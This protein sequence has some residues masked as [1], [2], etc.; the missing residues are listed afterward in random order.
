MPMLEVGLNLPDQQSTQSMSST[1]KATA[2]HNNGL[3]SA[4]SYT[5]FGY[6]VGCPS[7]QLAPA[8]LVHP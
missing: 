7:L 8:S 6:G 5:S 4:R 2:L 3:T 1:V